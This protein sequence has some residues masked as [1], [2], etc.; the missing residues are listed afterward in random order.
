MVDKTNM[1]REIKF[2]VWAKYID[3]KYQMFNWEE[4]DQEIC[5]W[6]CGETDNGWEDGR[7]MQFTGLKDKNGVEI[8]EGDIVKYGDNIEEVIFTDGMF[9]VIDWDLITATMVEDGCEVIGNIYET[10]DQIITP[11]NNG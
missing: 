7:L 3:D 4:D 2:R 10:P 1:R 6:L 8:Y 11:I 5:W 9:K